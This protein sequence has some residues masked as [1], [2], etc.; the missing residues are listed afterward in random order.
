MIVSTVLF[1]AYMY[2][3]VYSGSG[4]SKYEDI[5]FNQL[6]K[7]VDSLIYRLNFLLGVAISMISFVFES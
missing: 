1:N 4:L 2:N 6:K 7:G 3:V 5:L